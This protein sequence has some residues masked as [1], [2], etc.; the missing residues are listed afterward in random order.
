MTYKIFFIQSKIYH[1]FIPALEND[2]NL[3]LEHFVEA[4]SGFNDISN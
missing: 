3:Y 1:L 4:G 2:E